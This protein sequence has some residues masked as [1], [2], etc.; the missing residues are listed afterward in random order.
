MIK[1]GLLLMLSL[2]WLQ[3]CVGT[4]KIAQD[5][6]INTLTEKTPTITKGGLSV[7]KNQDNNQTHSK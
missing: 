2:M 3:G 6:Q 5:N 7:E 4:V 1:K